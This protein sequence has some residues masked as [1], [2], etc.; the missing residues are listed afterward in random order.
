MSETK[1]EKILT[2]LKDNT[3]NEEFIKSELP[4]KCEINYFV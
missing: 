2:K 1:I 4:E 3:F